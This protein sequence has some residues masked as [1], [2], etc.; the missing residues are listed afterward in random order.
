MAAR[1]QI[2]TLAAAGT[3]HA[4]ASTVN[5]TGVVFREA[6]RE[7]MIVLDVTAAAAASGD[8]LDVYIDTSPDG[9][10]S[11]INVGHFTQVLGN[12]GAKKF[13]M[14]LRADNPGASAVT[15]VTSNA[16]AGVTRQY[17][18]TDR[19]RYRSIVASASAPSFTFG[20]TAFL[21]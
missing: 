5:G 13:V 21:K 17:G 10:T 8:T 1:S 18:I 9:G 3:V 11:W 19:L 15:D 20:I 4:G 14:A 7:A 16:S 6:F 2:I 12:G